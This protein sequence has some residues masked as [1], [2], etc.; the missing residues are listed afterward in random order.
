MVISLS[1][2]FESQSE[3]ASSVLI[4]S[5]KR[6]ASTLSVESAEIELFLIKSP[7]N[8]SVSRQKRLRK[9]FQHVQFT[10]YKDETSSPDSYSS[11]SYRGISPAHSASK[12]GSV[13]SHISV[14]LPFQSGIH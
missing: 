12:L 4:S 13:Q 7:L 6:S 14:I 10:V 5:R 11:N 1:I 8:S 9:V 3:I 2:P